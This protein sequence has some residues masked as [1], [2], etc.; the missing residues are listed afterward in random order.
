M[1][2]HKLIQWSQKDFTDLPW[3]KKRTLYG[4][5]VSEIML[6]QTTVGTVKNHFEKF[7]QRFPDLQ[8]LAKA[9]EEEVIVAW[10]GLGYYRRARNLKKISEHL[11]NE[12][13]GKFPSTALELQKI[14]G[15]G[16]YTSHAL[17]AIGKD[18][19]GLAVDANLERVIAR[20]YGLE[21]EKGPK[22][23]KKILELFEADEIFSGFNLSYRAL[24]EALMDLGRTFCQARKASCE[25]CPL[26]TDCH[27][28]KTK[29][30][31]SFP[32]E[33][34]TG[35]K[36]SQEHELHLLRILIISKNK[37]LVYKK[38]ETEWLSGQYELPTLVISSTDKN[39]KQYP[40]LETKKIDLE[41]KKF[42]TGITKYK[43]TNF[44][45]ISTL[46]NLKEMGFRA[47]SEWKSLDD[48]NAN[49]STAS[50]KALKLLATSQK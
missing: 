39:F 6:Q 26:K 50:Y 25:L 47:E 37:V 8:S 27:A 35:K 24:N 33:K 18:A 22:L 15:I 44:I 40:K 3:R 17:I 36:A 4:T 29:K 46:K 49:L 28:F 9:S 31:L 23:Q 11:V 19:R 45:L 20:L 1:S 21:F 38:S 10:K 16:P 32:L 13:K 43:I 42:K 41:L 12:F 48:E 30:Q 14:P 2:L 5:L 34:S 7:L